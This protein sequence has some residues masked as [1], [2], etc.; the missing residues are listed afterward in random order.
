MGFVNAVARERC[1]SWDPKGRSWLNFITLLTY[2]QVKKTL[3]RH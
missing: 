1:R 3:Q 2:S